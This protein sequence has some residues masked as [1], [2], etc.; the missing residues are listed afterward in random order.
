MAVMKRG[1]PGKGGQRQ[2][3]TRQFIKLSSV[4]HDIKIKFTWVSKYSTAKEYKKNG[5]N[6]MESELGSS[7]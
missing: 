7:K 3:K 2:D 1:Q 4:L 6:K 5:N